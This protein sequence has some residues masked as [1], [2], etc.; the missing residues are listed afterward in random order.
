MPGP[1]SVTVIR[2]SPSIGGDPDLDGDVA[3]RVDERV[4][5]D[6]GD[7]LAQAVLVAGHDDRA[8]ERRRDRTV[9]I[10]RAGVA[11]GVGGQ[12]EQVDRPAVERPALVELGQ[13][14]QVVD[15]AGHAD[16]LLLGAPHRL[17]EL[18]RLVEAADPVQL[19]VAADRRDGRTQLVGRVG[20]EPAQPV[21]RLG[22]LGERPLQRLAS[23]WLRATPSSP[24][25]GG[26]RRLRDTVGQVAAGDLAS[27]CGSSA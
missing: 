13:R 1:W 5:D 18:G 17:V 24:G 7:H 20:D 14:Q 10:D 9:G 8:G 22:P 6:V 4:A 3:R 11:G 21:L 16:G 19:G 15:E 26:R 23:M 27:P 2:A 12:A 25:L